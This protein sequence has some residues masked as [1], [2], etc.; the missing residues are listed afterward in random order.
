[1]NRTELLPLVL[2]LALAAG[3]MGWIIWS[4]WP[5]DPVVATQ[6]PPAQI[7]A[8]PEVPPPS[9]P[10][11]RCAPAAPPLDAA[12]PRV[13]PTLCGAPNLHSQSVMMDSGLAGKCTCSR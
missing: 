9:R 1:M 5:A 8:A 3:L 2:A 7:P 11:R 4:Q 6:A 12:A 10:L 13:E